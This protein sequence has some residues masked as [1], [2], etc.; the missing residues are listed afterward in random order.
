VFQLYAI[1][2]VGIA[3]AADRGYLLDA[4]PREWLTPEISAA[5]AIAPILLALLG[6]W[7]VVCVAASRLARRRGA[8]WIVAAERALLGAQ[9][10]ILISYAG[11]VLACGWHRWVQVFFGGDVILA[12]LIITITPPLLG[13]WLTWIIHYPIVRRLRD[14][15]ALRALDEGVPLRPVQGR[16]RYALLQM[17]LHVLFLLIPLLLIVTWSEI[18]ELWFDGAG[19]DPTEALLSEAAT[20]A[21]AVIVFAVAPVI[22]RLVLEL[23]TMPS[24]QVRDDLLQ[25]CRDHKVNVRDVL[26]WETDGAMINGAV[27]GILG[28]LRYVMLTDALLESMRREQVHAVM[29]HEIGHV[30]RHHIPWLI[31][32]L[33][34]AILLPSFVADWTMRIA[35]ASDWLHGPP[36]WWMDAGGM[37][38]ILGVAFVMFGWISRRFERQ[39]DAFAVQHLSGLREARG[40]QDEGSEITPDAA[41]AMTT[42]LELVGTLN[43]VDPERR[44]WRHGSIRWRQRNLV[45]LVGRPLRRLP[46]DRTVQWIKA[47]VAVVLLVLLPFIIQDVI[48]MSQQQPPTPTDTR[49]ELRRAWEEW[50][51]MND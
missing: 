43:A 20:L 18:V 34:S 1:I 10:I 31:A 5:A 44:S 45:S 46:I 9:W 16:L 50:R 11:S 33:M 19:V 51:R 7:L 47:A 14:A 32:A 49:A 6:Q 28:R 15:I 35:I 48:M 22:A 21:G 42:A 26:L 37:F 25:I 2:I 13:L 40:E 17:R 38:A 24:G 30:R 41:A 29:A 4:F 8:R 39:A 23:R 3:H 12:D 36:A 27:M